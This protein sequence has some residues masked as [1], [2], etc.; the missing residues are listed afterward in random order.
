MKENNLKIT[1]TITDEAPMLATYSLFPIL[2]SYVSK[3]DILLEKKN[4]SLSSRVL[5]A[6]PD[7]LQDT[8]RVND[9]L[10]DLGRMVQDKDANIIKLPN[11]IICCLHSA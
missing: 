9:D 1:Y 10:S 3:A 5:S 6:F 7:Y 2:K 11:I 8:Q 4:I